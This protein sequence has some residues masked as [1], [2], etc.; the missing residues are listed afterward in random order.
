MATTIE[1]IY[2]Y[3][4]HNRQLRVLFVFDALDTISMELMGI[5]WKTGFRL[6]EFDGR[7]WFNMKYHLET[8]WKDDKVVLV[9]H[10][11]YP[12][13][14]EQMLDFPLMDLL[15]ANATY[16]EETYVEFM[17]QY[18][19]PQSMEVFVS[20]HI[21]ELRQKKFADVLKAYYNPSDFTADN[22]CRGF[23]SVYLKQKNVLN[24][25]RIIARI[26]ILGKAE[27]KDARDA[28]FRVLMGNRDA[29]EQ[30]QSRLESITG[31][32]YLPNS[33][34]K[35]KNVAEA[36][37]YN[38][39]CQ[40]LPQN[41]TDRYGRY[42]IV[43]G[44]TLS[45]FNQLMENIRNDAQLSGEFQK[46]INELGK[47]IQEEE[48]I[49]TYGVD[50]PFN[51]ITD[52]LCWP[53]LRQTIDDLMPAQSHQALARLQPMIDE[54]RLTLDATAEEAIATLCCMASYFV[55][56][57]AAGSFLLSSPDEYVNRYTQEFY[58]LD[59]CYRLSLEHFYKLEAAECPI[60]DDI[61]KMKLQMDLQY[62]QKCNELNFEWVK[63]L[64]EFGSSFSEVHL[65]RQQDFYKDHLEISRMKQVVIVSDAMRYEVAM[66]L[67]QELSKEQHPHT[68]AG[69]LAMLPTETKYCKPSMLPHEMLTL[70]GTEMLLDGNSVVTT[71]Q[72]SMQVGRYKTGGVAI[73]YKA[74]MAMD[75]SERREV[76][77]APLV[78]VFHDRID[79]E[80]H[81][82]NGVELTRACRDTVAELAWLVNHIHTSLNVTEV[83]ITADHGF[84]YEDRT[85][86][87]KD[88]HPVQEENVE[89]KTRYY[90]TTS[91]DGMPGIAKFDLD[92][93][94]G[95]GG[96]GLK[97]AV[98]TGTNRMAAAGGYNF[99]HGGA[100]LQEL[101]IPVIHSMRKKGDDRDKVTVSLISNQQELTIQSSIL[102][103]RLLQNEAV[104]ADRLPLVVRYAVY[105]NGG[106]IT[107]VES[108]TLDS[109]STSTQERIREFTLTV[110]HVPAGVS[111]LELRVYADGDEHNPLIS[112][113]VRN[114]TLIEQDF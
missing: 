83:F 63:C 90:L 43:N 29:D 39:I 89:K 47:A 68:I 34:E 109:T 111:I 38:T 32:R 71:D 76:M 81:D 92:R 53:I 19:L 10:Q 6:V 58:L 30:L 5:E 107:R 1:R 54:H 20:N 42:K 88:K 51:Q 65:A 59:T 13:T 113:N 41:P 4:E 96:S 69:A 103:F 3:F 84:L 2:S 78:F 79:K 102:K 61:R 100:S 97:I 77:K 108:V 62:S 7:S 105:A 114:A 46:A 28:F 60:Y 31:Q 45:R 22:I 55:K 21:D 94:S 86:A 35:V 50:A 26:I 95:I 98:P 80:G 106:P 36:I 17:E 33:E 64:Q 85:F 8:D 67:M 11:L 70:K 48:L 101:V 16:R 52:A 72:R 25:D 49:R 73:E 99:A 14:Q 37:K 112:R 93:V 75:M 66:E 23:I 57:N 91:R 40:N 9:L 24:W 56:A 82:Q 27:K 44:L 12:E 87:E 15:V 104:T 110:Q 74:L 18:G